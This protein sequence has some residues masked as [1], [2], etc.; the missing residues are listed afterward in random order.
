MNSALW[1]AYKVCNV[2]IVLYADVYHVS[3]TD[4]QPTHIYDIP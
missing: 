4:I 2:K 1:S 3:V